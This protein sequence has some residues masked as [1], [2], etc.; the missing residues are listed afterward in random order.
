LD[1]HGTIGEGGWLMSR[2]A[3]IFKQNDVTKA[4]KG[5]VRA[6]LEVQ[7]VEIDQATGKIVVF[8]GKPADPQIAKPANEWDSFK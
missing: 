2:G 1:E 3:Q 8:A 4:C 5:A 7:R 6:G